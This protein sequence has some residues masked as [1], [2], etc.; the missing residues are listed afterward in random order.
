MTEAEWL[1][2]T[3]PQPM[4]E[5]LRGKVGDR[6]VRLF[7]VACCRRIWKL[8]TDEPGRKA[9]E[10][11]ERYADAPERRDELA[12]AREAAGSRASVRAAVEA[13]SEMSGMAAAAARSRA[14]ALSFA[15]GAAES[16]AELMPGH[17]L[18]GASRYASG[19]TGLAAEAEVKRQHK[20]AAK[21]AAEKNEAAAQTDLLR[22]IVNNPFR[23][24]TFAPAWRTPTVA[25][26]TEAIYDERAFDRLPI[27]ADA[28]E[29]AGCTD[30]DILGHCRSTGEHVRGCWVVDLILGKQ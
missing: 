5:F 14:G 22:D 1:A 27:L 6:K 23:P 30:A 18:E 26:L 16:A 20:K 28:L 2:C 25:A 8:L 15:V 17:H 13:V 29:D 11:A 19:A 21:A 7:A 3:D 4:L 12:A 10:E 24:Q 9:V